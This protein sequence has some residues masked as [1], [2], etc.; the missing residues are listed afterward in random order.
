MAK[1]IDSLL[2]K[3]GWSGEEVGKALIASV[4]HDV[5]HRGEPDFKPLF[6]QSDFE[7]M[8][9][10]LSSDRD[11]TVYG[12]Y[13]DLYSSIIDAYNRGQ[14][15]FQQFYNGYSRYSN[16][17]FMCQN[18]EIALERADKVPLI[19]TQSQY[20]RHRERARATLN[21]ANDGSKWSF[22]SLLFVDLMSFI[23]T[24]EEAPEHIREL[25]EATKKETATNPRILG[26]YNKEHSKGYYTLPDGRRS[27]KL[28]DEEWEQ[29]LEE[30]YLKTHSLVINGRPATPE[31]THKF[32]NE[33][34]K[35]KAYKLFF[36]GIEGIKALYKE[37][38]GKELDGVDAEE[39]K[40][41]L[42]TLEDML[43]LKFQTK[44]LRERSEE[45]KY[46]L[47]PLQDLIS[48]LLDG[49]IDSS[50]V[51][52]YY[53]DPPQLTKYEVLTECWEHYSGA[54]EDDIDEKDQLKEFKADYPALFSAL[55]AYIK[56]SAPALQSLKPSQYCK[57]VISIEE[58]AGRSSMGDGSD[59]EPS[60]EDII[61]DY[62][63]DF[64]SDPDTAEER[65]RRYRRRRRGFYRGIAIIQN[66]ASWQTDENGDYKET[67]D[68]LSVFFN[69]DSVADSE[70]Q[71]TELDAFRNNL[72]KPALRFL[73]AY[74]ALMLIIG[75]VYDI[76]DTEALQLSTRTFESQLEG[77]NNLLYM[78][79]G[80]VYGDPEEKQRKRKLIKELFQPTDPEELKP[81]KEAIDAVTAELTELGYTT[82][83]RK[84]L[85]N[86]DRYIALLMGEG[87]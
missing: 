66:P 41:L 85:K 43:D 7:R 80:G 50:I 60:N 64:E 15:L 70:T 39:E 79:Y 3:K 20:N 84:N 23:D 68:P 21:D 55:E 44:T 76:E 29:A 10:S 26:A 74:N 83:A 16:V 51:W 56:E 61:A 6:S 46:P 63:G 42:D 58:L 31:E 28:T 78:F 30:L 1:S 9:S 38:T 12:V 37:I 17:M 2:K 40:R 47:S 52:S 32:Y 4:I 82:K 22:S 18:A 81:T 11:Y 35:L 33:Q 75:A 24:P 87:A 73:Y 71:R 48:G 8:E 65:L 53:P 49:N 59:I 5:K 86:F 57:E 13:R 25:I 77:F 27:D 19:M 62:C 14:A 45:G 72:F 54:Y 34:Q 69:L 36:D 67:P